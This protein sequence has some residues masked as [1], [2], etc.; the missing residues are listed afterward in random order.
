MP[1]L[2][3]LQSSVPHLSLQRGMGGLTRAE[4]LPLSSLQTATTGVLQEP[5]PVPRAA[6]TVRRGIPLMVSQLPAWAVLHEAFD[7]EVEVWRARFLAFAAGAA[8][9]GIHLVVGTRSLGRWHFDTMP[10][11]AMILGAMRASVGYVAV[12][13]RHVAGARYEA[14]LRAG[15]L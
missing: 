2:Q 9:E 1:Y 15:S 13:D 3:R 14:I 5:D 6:G 8:S 11:C 7:A 10:D 4:I 12:T